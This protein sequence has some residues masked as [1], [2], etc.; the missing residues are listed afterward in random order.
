MA[1]ESLLL[2]T[3]LAAN[4]GYGHD[5]FHLSQALES[6]GL[7]TRLLPTIVVPPVPMETARLLTKDLGHEFDYLLHHVDPVQMSLGR[8]SR[9]ARRRVAWSMWEFTSFGDSG[10]DERLAERLQDYDL[11]LAYDLVSREAFT[12][13]AQ[14]AGVP[15]KVLQGGYRSQDWA[16]FDTRERDWDGVFRFGM[17]GQLHQRKNPFASI[18]AMDLLIEDGRIKPDEVEMHL[19]TTVRYLHPGLCDT[20]PWLHIH[21]A[22]WTQEELRNFYSNLHTLLAPSWGEGKNLPAM[23]AMTMGVPV[24]YSDFGGH[25]MWGGSEWGWPVTGPLEE[26]EG[27]GMPSMRVDVEDLAEAMYEAFSDRVLTRRKGDLAARTIPSM[28]DWSVVVRTL[29]DILRSL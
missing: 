20:R 25:Q 28:C 18:H 16:G 22:V 19:K 3:T 7:D 29:H 24:I 23:E 13:A 4:T 21:Y 26:H 10:A 12:P 1:V 8:E 14:E 17:N 11:L 27:S 15:I 9:A 2:K 6:H 5:G